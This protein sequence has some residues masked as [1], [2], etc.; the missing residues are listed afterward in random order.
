MWVVIK[1]VELAVELT[2][3]LAYPANNPALSCNPLQL[4]KKYMHIHTFFTYIHESICLF[5]CFVFI[6]LVALSFIY[7]HV[8]I[9][10]R[11]SLKGSLGSDLTVVAKRRPV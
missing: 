11:V 2:S 1:C 9:G 7:L 3:K 8:S 6:D 10:L 5:M 4:V